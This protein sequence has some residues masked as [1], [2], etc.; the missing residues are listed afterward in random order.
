MCKY[1]VRGTKRKDNFEILQ[2]EKLEKVMVKKRK[3][4]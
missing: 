2:W 3:E 1:L 4:F